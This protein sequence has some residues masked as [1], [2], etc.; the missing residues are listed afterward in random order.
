MKIII[1]KKNVKLVLNLSKLL[2]QEQTR[3]QKLMKWKKKWI[4]LDYEVIR[5]VEWNF[6]NGY[7]LTDL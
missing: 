3:Q 5:Q 7:S 2:Q 1:L 6:N 4:Q